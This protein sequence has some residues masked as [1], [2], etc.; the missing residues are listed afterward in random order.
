MSVNFEEIRKEFP[1]AEKVTYLDAGGFALPPL[2][3]IKAMTDS[4]GIMTQDPSKFDMESLLLAIPEEVRR[5]TG[6][7]VNASSGEIAFVNRTSGGLSIA[8]NGIKFEKG[9]NVI[10]GDIE[11]PANVYPWLLLKEKGVEVKFVKNRGGAILPEDYEK[12]ID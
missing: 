10:L 11:Y 9:D 2:R 1:A 7:L 5:K 3:V 8:A 12:A 4:L 6:E